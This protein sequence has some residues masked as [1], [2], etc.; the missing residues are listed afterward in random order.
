MA[1][2]ERLFELTKYCAENNARLI[3]VSKT[4]SV[5]EIMEVYNAGQR[6]FG[7]NRVQE[8]MA[9]H[10]EMPEDTE[11]HMIGHLQRNK[12]K[13]IIS[14]VRMIQS[15]DSLR[16]AREI[17]RQAARCGRNVAVLLQV[18]IARESSKFG[19]HMDELRELLGSGELQSM[20]FI[21]IAGLMGMATF[22]DDT[23][24]VRAE[25]R[26]LHDCFE[27]IRT[28]YFEEEP[29]FREISMGM[30]GDYEIALE[31]GSTMVRVGSAIFGS[32]N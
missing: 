31:E 22:T 7:E 15:V 23:D 19:F 5:E 20:P 21:Q 3:A 26:Y 8:L 4:K 30:T 16:L 27:E 1:N 24:I 18:H 6:A 9:K 2:L 32:R 13:D 12:V 11:W 25:F 14:Y 10:S 29:S 17:N 28:A